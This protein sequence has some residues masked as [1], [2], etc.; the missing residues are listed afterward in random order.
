MYTI[1]VWHDSENY[2]N[3]KPCDVEHSTRTEENALDLIY[4]H[5]Q[6]G[7]IGDAHSAIR[8]FGPD[9]KRI[10]DLLERMINR[11]AT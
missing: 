4:Q 5:Q 7:L 10:L 3:G 11:F 6:E 8:L 1:K 2:K 9:G